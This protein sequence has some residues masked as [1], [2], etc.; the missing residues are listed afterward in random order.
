[1]EFNAGNLSAEVYFYR[2]TT[3]NKILHDELVIMKE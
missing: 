3:A 1:M 2:T